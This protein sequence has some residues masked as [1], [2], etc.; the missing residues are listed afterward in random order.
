MG[1]YMFNDKNIYF[2]VIEVEK[3]DVNKAIIFENF[4]SP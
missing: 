4:F 3:K 2:Y 1:N